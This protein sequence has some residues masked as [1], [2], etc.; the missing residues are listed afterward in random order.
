MIFLA[1]PD[2]LPE[3]QKTETG[4]LTDQLLSSSSLVLINA[5]IKDVIRLI[6]VVQVINDLPNRG[7]NLKSSFLTISAI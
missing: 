3:G 1:V 2:L 7:V 5:V 4:E 6:N